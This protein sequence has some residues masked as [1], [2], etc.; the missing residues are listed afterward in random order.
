MPRPTL[1]PGGVD[2][3]LADMQKQRSPLNTQNG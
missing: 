3:A 1:L 2:P